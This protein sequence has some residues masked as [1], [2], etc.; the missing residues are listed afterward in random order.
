MDEF[1]PHLT[2]LLRRP[3]AQFVVGFASLG[4][5]IYDNVKSRY[6]PLKVGQLGPS[7][8]RANIQSMNNNWLNIARVKWNMIKSGLSQNG[9][10]FFLTLNEFGG[11]GTMFLRF[12][13]CD[14][15]RWQIIISFG[16]I[17]L[18]YVFQLSKLV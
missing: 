18:R 6:L 12:F 17:L 9:N 13:V 16:S 1:L 2:R 5:F 14:T 7:N 3:L 10:D 11:F 15:S 4:L 8:N